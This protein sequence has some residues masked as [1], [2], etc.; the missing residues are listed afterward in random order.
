MALTYPQARDYLRTELGFGGTAAELALGAVAGLFTALSACLRAA[1][2]VAFHLDLR[3]R[4]EGHDLE[5][6]LAR[7]G[8]AQAG[9][10][11]AA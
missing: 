2:M 7:A 11:E 1:L 6:A 3:V 8:A 9:A 10:P 5:L 4:R